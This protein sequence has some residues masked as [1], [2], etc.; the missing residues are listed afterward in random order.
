MCAHTLPDC[1]HQNDSL[2][3]VI[4]HLP[5]MIRKRTA[6]DSLSMLEKEQVA[7][8]C[9]MFTDG[10]TVNILSGKSE[11]LDYL[12]REREN[13]ALWVGDSRNFSKF[14][15]QRKQLE[16]EQISRCPNRGSAFCHSFVCA[17]V[18]AF[19]CVFSVSI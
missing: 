19:Q 17:C 6:A 10:C 5:P 8:I 2:K 13:T 1:L 16:E 18:Q 15:H 9:E 4:A 3:G 14:L 11:L 7:R 12:E